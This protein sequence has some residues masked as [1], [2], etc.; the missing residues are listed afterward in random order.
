[1]K[2]VFNYF[3]L[4]LLALTGSAKVVKNKL[5]TTDPQGEVLRR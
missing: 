5:T 1:M 4:E 2:A 3:V